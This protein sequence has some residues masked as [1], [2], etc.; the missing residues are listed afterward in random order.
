MAML[1]AV[2]GDTHGIS[3][4]SRYTVRPIDRSV[5]AWAKA[6]SIEG[7]MLRPSIWQPLVPEPRTA[8]ALRAF[9]ALEGHF[10]HSINSGL[11]F[12]IFDRE[13]EF[14]RAKSTSQGGDLYWHELDPDHDDFEIIG[15]KQMIDAMDFPLVCVALSVDAF[16]RKPDDASRALYECMPLVKAL[17]TYLARLDKRPASSRQPD[18]RGEVMIRSGCVTKLGYEGR[19]LMTAL[20][21]FVML[22]A[23][24]RGYGAVT[25]GIGS[26]TVY[27]SW[28]NAPVGCLSSVI[29][30][31]DIWGIELEDEEGSLVRPYADSGVSREG[32]LIWCDLRS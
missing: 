3:L 10:A 27:R 11:C 20:N 18:A 30:Y 13:Y 19:G 6:L 2:V 26:P 4:P 17:G 15:E 7:F 14:R 23:K 28:M 25:A 8:N 29:A 21:H 32:W 16:D 31:F 24:A 9:T 5:A 12:G 1:P 22:E